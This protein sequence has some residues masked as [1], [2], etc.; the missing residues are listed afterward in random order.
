MAVSSTR[1]Q[2]A[3]SPKGDVTLVNLQRQLAMI[4]CCA[5]NHSSVTARCERL[6]AI[7]AV[8]QR[9]LNFWK[10][11]K[12]VTCLQIRAKNMRCESA[13]QVDQCNITLNLHYNLS[14]SCREHTYRVW[15]WIESFG[16]PNPLVTLIPFFMENSC[17]SGENWQRPDIFAVHVVVERQATAALQVQASSCDSGFC[18]SV[19]PRRFNVHVVSLWLVK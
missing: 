16:D 18:A 7:F 2:S 5:K 12:S 6:F 8:L 15:R 10:R 4:W 3:A 14:Q 9:V 17:L 13:L 1:G 19:F 11:F